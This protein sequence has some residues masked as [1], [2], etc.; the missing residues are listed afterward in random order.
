MSEKIDY[1]DNARDDARDMAEYFIDEI[2]S[3]LRASGEASDDVNNDYDD[4]DAYH[5]G[6]HVDRAYRLTEAS[7]ILDQLA[8]WEADDEG[9]WA[10]QDPREAISTQAAFTY[11]NAVNDHWETVIRR[12]NDDAA[13][14]I[15]AD[16]I[17][18]DDP[19]DDATVTERVREIIKGTW[20]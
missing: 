11:G 9:L 18:E 5:H 12:I 2:V 13:S 19:A 3:Q 15:L 6:T 10:G 8:Q 20:R 7:A 17:G 16:M 4:G 1:V 14:G